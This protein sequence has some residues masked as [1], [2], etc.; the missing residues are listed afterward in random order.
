MPN[1][2]KSCMYNAAC[3][4][5]NHD[6]VVGC[7]TSATRRAT[8]TTLTAFQMLWW[9]PSS[10]AVS[11]S[12]WTYQDPWGGACKEGSLQSP[13]RLDERNATE[14]EDGRYDLD[15]SGVPEQV[16]N[17]TV[18]NNFHGSPQIILPQ[19]SCKVTFGGEQFDLI[20]IHFHSPSEH[21]LNNKR[22]PM[23]AHLVHRSQENEDRLLVIAVLLERGEK[24]NVLLEEALNTVP[25]DD[26]TVHLQHSIPLKSLF[27]IPEI[28][29]QENR[30]RNFY[31][32][33]GSL[34]TPPCSEPVTWLVQTPMIQM[35]SITKDQIDRFSSLSVIPGNSRRLQDANGRSVIK[36]KLR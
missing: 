30:T 21:L 3:R 20:Q 29:K 2:M 11:Q 28:P 36:V 8:L 9:S 26:Q 6:S 7:R 16:G 10:E 33:T 17:V 12:S 1:V 24:R 35:G 4:L 13:I 22:F 15:I 27:G 19:G 32:Y 5:G 25:L 14:T 31:W 18:I 23:E 34:T